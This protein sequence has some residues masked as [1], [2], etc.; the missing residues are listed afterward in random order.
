MIS[1]S[2]WSSTVLGNKPKEFDFVHQTV[3][4][5]EAC[6]GHETSWPYQCG[7][8]HQLNIVSMMVVLIVRNI[9]VQHNI[10]QYTPTLRVGKQFGYK[11]ET[12][13]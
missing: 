9:T 3:S 7:H 8:A 6:C 5:R 11:N 1:Q 4:R 12:S 10:H 13:D 2:H